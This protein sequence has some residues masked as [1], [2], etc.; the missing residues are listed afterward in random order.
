MDIQRAKVGSLFIES[1]VAEKNEFWA[2][3]GTNHSGIDELFKFVSGGIKAESANKI[4]LPE[5][6]GIVSFEKQ[7]AFYEAELKK[8]DTDFIDKIDPGTPV[9]T[10]I[11]NIGDHEQMIDSFGLSDCINQGYRQLS[12]GQS[13]KLLLLSE[14]SKNR[15]SIIIQS[16]FDGLDRQ[17]RFELSNALKQL[18]KQNILVLVFIHDPDDI[19]SFC[20]HIGIMGKYKMSIQ[21]TKDLIMKQTRTWV[22]MLLKNQSQGFNATV[23][24]LKSDH[25]YCS[26]YSD[27]SEL[28]SLKNGTAGYNGNT[29][30]K[31]LSLLIHEGDHT[32]VSGPNGSGKSTLLQLIT[33]D[34]PACYQNDLKIFGHQRGT[35]ESIW[36]LKKD[37]GII[38]S[39]LHR[40]YYVPGTTLHCV[41]S[42]FFDSI[43]LYQ[44]YTSQHESEALK[45]LSRIHL[46]EKADTSF[47]EL[48]FS[49]Q[50]LILIA[51]ALIKTP[52]LLILDEPTQGIDEINRKAFLDF[53]EEIALEKICT[54]LYVSHREDEFRDFFVQHIKISLI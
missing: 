30:F 21:G 15:D 24:D 22:P 8:D 12:T 42:G 49:D 39:D 7:Q 2:I 48:K 45:W 13:R 26:S 50:R 18:N 38:S 52:K 17:S 32:L 34:H 3:L 54:I 28:I 51:R 16:P 19:P 44:P 37:M 11:N 41:I 9:K 14:F 36:E 33:G 53:L 47:R 27:D 31:N 4:D 20:T 43:G 35:G 10:F 40:N 25:I 1:F 29:I 6:I 5:N 46:S 23:K